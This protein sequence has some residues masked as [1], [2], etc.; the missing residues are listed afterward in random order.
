MM[1]INKLKNN[2]A[3]NPETVN[4]SIQ[5]AAILITI[6]LI[7]KR[8]SPKVNNVRGKVRIMSNGLMV[9]FSKESTTATIT[10]SQALVTS[11]NGSNQ[12]PA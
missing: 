9:T 7:T 11:T 8:K 12:A 10:A 5:L 6:A 2:A 4:P 3:Q 1:E